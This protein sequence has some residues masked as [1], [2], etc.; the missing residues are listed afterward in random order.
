MARTI[1]KLTDLEVRKL[2]EPGL[3]GDGA[4]LYLQV[5]SSGTKSWIYRFMLNGKSREMGLGA[6]LVVSLKEARAAAAD[7][8]K[9]RHQGIDPIEARRAARVQAALE[10][11]KAIT[12]S[13]AAVQ[14]IESYRRG[15]RNEKHAAQWKATLATY[16]EPVFGKM[17]I[18][19]VDTTLIMKVLEPIWST[20]PETA[21]RVRGRIEAVLNWATARGFRGGENPAR[22][23]GHLDKLLPKRGKL[24][25]VKHHAALPYTQVQEFISALKMMPGMAARALEFTILTAARTGEVIGARASEIDHKGKA[26]I[27]PADRMKAGREHRVPLSDRALEI[28]KNLEP[29]TGNLF[30]FPGRNAGAG[31]SNMSLLKVLKLMN[32]ADITVHGFRSTFRDWAAEHTDYSSE[33]V[34]MAL[35]HTISDKTEAAYRRG[36]LFDKRRKLMSAW[37][38]FCMSSSAEVIPLRSRKPDSG[39]LPI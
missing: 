39:K 19:A 36:D 14:Y 13:E 16:V 2:S 30:L 29:V 20:K 22:W 27:V 21:A 8:R 10:A 28:V 6:V 4:G 11:A 12:F 7:A 1:A 23:R 25:K 9:Q 33:V 38:S 34:E 18:Q 35:A 32:R 24:E 26:W 37:A 31:L 3:Y 5:S 17:S 15:W